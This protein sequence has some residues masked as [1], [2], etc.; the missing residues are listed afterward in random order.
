MAT[1]FWIL[2]FSW[3]TNA[4]YG[5][6][7]TKTS[8]CRMVSDGKPSCVL[9]C[10]SLFSLTHT[11][12]TEWNNHTKRSILGIPVV[13]FLFPNDFGFHS[14]WPNDWF[15]WWWIDFCVQIPYT[16]RPIV[17]LFYWPPRQLQLVFMV[18]SYLQ[19]HD[20]F[21]HSDTWCKSERC[22]WL[23]WLYFKWP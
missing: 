19:P 22:P 9:L 5:C 23:P 15:P 21:F 11:T 1:H 20:L 3:T 18:T 4:D 14:D 12:N 10:Y 8:Q 17:N 13:D 6:T 2:P 7:K 16:V